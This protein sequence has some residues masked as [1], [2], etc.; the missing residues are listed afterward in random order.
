M[1]GPDGAPVT[2][3]QPT[4]ETEILS[5]VMNEEKDDAAERLTE[6]LPSELADYYTWLS[7]TLGLVT[8]EM[9]RRPAFRGRVI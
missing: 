5:L 6:F 8:T 9:R 1:I 2:G 7:E 3:H 4:A